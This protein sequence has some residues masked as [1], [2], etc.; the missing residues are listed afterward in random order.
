MMDSR[1][2]RA[3]LV[4]YLRQRP[5]AFALWRYSEIAALAGTDWRGRILDLG[6]GD[7][8]LGELLFADC[9]VVGIDKC[10]RAL[11]L[12]RRRDVYR[13]V[14]QGDIHALPLPDA[15]FDMVFSNCVVEH[16]DDPVRAFR[17]AR[18]VLVPGGRFLFTVPSERFSEMLFGSR[19]LLRA[20]LRSLAARYGQ[21]A[22]RFLDHKHLLT[23][24]QWRALLEPA[25]FEAIEARYYAGPLVAAAF[26]LG[27]LA[28]APSLVMRRLTSRWWVLPKGP[29]GAAVAERLVGDVTPRTGAGLLVEARASRA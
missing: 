20:G 2:K 21:F 24:A 26:D 11:D 16:L 19:L 23:A 15:S 25:G 4:Q 13:E 14:S 8:L 10:E 22:N 1:D 5:F 27:G 7:G 3:S 29:L 9:D 12:A 28:A 17:E 6:C 18:R